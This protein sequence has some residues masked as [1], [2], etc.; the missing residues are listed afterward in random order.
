MSDA[1]GRILIGCI[2]WDIWQL[3]MTAMSWIF[4][5][6]ACGELRAVLHLLLIAY[7]KTDVSTQSDNQPCIWSQYQEIQKII[8][9]CLRSLLR[10]IHSSAIYYAH[11]FQRSW[12]AASKILVR[13]RRQL[14][15][16]PHGNLEH[17]SLSLSAYCHFEKWTQ[18]F[19][20]IY[21]VRQGVTTTVVVGRLQAAID[22]LEK[23][24]AATA[25]R[26]WS[27][28]AGETLSG[29]M[30][31][32]L[33]PSGERFKKMRRWTYFKFFGY[34]TASSA[35]LVWPSTNSSSVVLMTCFDNASRY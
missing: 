18:E 35:C 5:N 4:V 10:S 29:G 23:E 11:D 8:L 33:T 12:S 2:P 24:G 25:D 22:I 34:S 7:G 30:R 26:P 32:L 1:Q 19:G 9:V 13:S 31:V 16:G 15:P 6:R 21:T 28:A 27:I 14:P 3:I 17:I 20:P